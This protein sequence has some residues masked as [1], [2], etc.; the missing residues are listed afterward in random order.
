MTT[1]E[2]NQQEYLDLVAKNERLQKKVDRYEMFIYGTLRQFDKLIKE[3]MD[4]E[5]PIKI[6]GTE[7]RV[8]DVEMWPL[9]FL[10]AYRDELFGGVDTYVK[11][12]A[13]YKEER[14]DIE[15]KVR[16]LTEEEIDVLQAVNMLIKF[17]FS[18]MQQEN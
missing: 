1:I 3:E 10:R 13:L 14:Y 15:R 11:G 8:V 7:S 12:N 2:I 6:Q 4:D 9:H 16:D 18:R 17:E 5:K